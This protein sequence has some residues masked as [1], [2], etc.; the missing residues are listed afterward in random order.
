MLVAYITNPDAQHMICL[1]KA[2]GQIQQPLNILLSV[3]STNQE[4]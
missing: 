3:G 1:V 4:V 2:I